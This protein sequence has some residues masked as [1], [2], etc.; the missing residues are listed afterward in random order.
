[1]AIVISG[2]IYIL[3]CL[4]CRNG[5]KWSSPFL[6]HCFCSRRPEMGAIVILPIA[7][8]SLALAWVAWSGRLWWLESVFV[9][10]FGLLTLDALR[11]AFDDA[12]GAAGRGS[13]SSSTDASSGGQSGEGD[14]APYLLVAA[15]EVSLLKLE[16]ESSLQELVEKTPLRGVRVA[17]AQAASAIISIVPDADIIP[18]TE[19]LNTSVLGEYSKLSELC[20]DKIAEAMASDSK[21]IA[22]EMDNEELSKKLSEALAANR[23]YESVLQD[24]RSRPANAQP[25]Y[26]KMTPSQ[27]IEEESRLK[28]NLA[29]LQ[30]LA[31]SSRLEPIAIPSHFR[32]IGK[33]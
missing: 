31:K 20:Q 32:Q 18:W 13:S 8:L 17:A 29:K 11:R 10:I 25:D 30:E 12:E 7:I 26:G 19:S 14:G 6:P 22:T 21:R 28:E 24:L 3:A 33:L 4:F 1:M 23:K 15:P 27:R 9:C 16:A 2:L 5:G